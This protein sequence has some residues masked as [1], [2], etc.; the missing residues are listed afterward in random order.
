[1]PFAIRSFLIGTL[2]NHENVFLVFPEKTEARLSGTCFRGKDIE[3]AGNFSLW[4]T[5]SDLRRDAIFRQMLEDEVVK[6]AQGYIDAESQETRFDESIE[7]E[8]EVEV[9]WASTSPINDF[10]DED[11]EPFEPNKRVTGM[12]VRLNSDK[13]APKT[14]LVTIVYSLYRHTDQMNWTAVIH[15]MY[16]GEDIGPLE[17]QDGYTDISER[18][19]IAFFDWNHPGIA[20]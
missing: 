4:S 12:R 15:S 5:F 18:E 17:V 7:I 13:L 2:T 1:M 20:A 3:C 19:G 16:P 6:A 8:H 10:D 11:L 14:R 9:G